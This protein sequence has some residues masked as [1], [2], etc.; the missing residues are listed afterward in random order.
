MLEIRIDGLN[1]FSPL[2]RLQ[3]F[4]GD[5][6]VFLFQECAF[7]V[8]GM[9]LES[10][11]LENLYFINYDTKNVENSSSVIPEPKLALNN[12]SKIYIATNVINVDVE[13]RVAG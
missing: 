2:W 9:P 7:D 12:A 10:F 1:S 13:F 11:Y 6:H 5:A 3:L 4:C 8:S